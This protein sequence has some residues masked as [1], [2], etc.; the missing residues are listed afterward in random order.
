MHKNLLC[1][2]KMAPERDLTYHNITLLPIRPLF[3]YNN[4][5]KCFPFSVCLLVLLGETH[6]LLSY[7]NHTYCSSL[8]LF[9]HWVV[10]QYGLIVT[11]SLLK[12]ERGSFIPCLLDQTLFHT[13]GRFE[14]SLKNSENAYPRKQVYKGTKFTPI[15]VW[16]HRTQAK[17]KIE[18]TCTM[19]MWFSA[20]LEGE[21][22]DW[23][24]P[25]VCSGGVPAPET[26]FE[27]I[28]MLAVFIGSDRS[29]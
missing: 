25:T 6:A 22:S 15:L 2:R 27:V 29:Y 19:I 23:E 5:A 11:F 4:R 20:V 3:A 18:D 17:N 21:T 7:R 8:R 9:W 14:A 1:K 26:H 12:K 28:I 24:P 16:A 13:G 10:P